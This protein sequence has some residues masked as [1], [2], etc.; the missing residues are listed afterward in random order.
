[1]LPS[2]LATSYRMAATTANKAIFTH[3]NSADR[4]YTLPNSSMTLGTSFAMGTLTRVTDAASGNVAYTG[5][6]FT[7]RL[8]IFLMGRSGGADVRM[9]V[10]VDNG[11]AHYAVSGDRGAADYTT[12][13]QFRSD[14]SISWEENGTTTRQHGSITTLDSDG[15]TIAW[16]K[17]GA[18][19]SIT[20]NVG[21][22]AIG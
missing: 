17:T 12:I 7:P 14:A 2:L 9:S 13:H 3:A 11:T 15:F 22:V 16:T 19:N 4:T 10:G 21:Y 8:V 20:A 18:P 1:M 6:G 5:V